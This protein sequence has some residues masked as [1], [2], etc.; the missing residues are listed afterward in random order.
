ML[1]NIISYETVRRFAL[2]VRQ[3]RIV[4][5]IKVYTGYVNKNANN[6]TMC[7]SHLIHSIFYLKNS[8][9]I[10]KI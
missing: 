8:V 4:I 5:A 10:W 1:C 6:L 3:N 7:L 2:L 9:D